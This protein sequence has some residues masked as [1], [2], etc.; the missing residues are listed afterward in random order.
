MPGAISAC[1]LSPGYNRALH[2]PDDSTSPMKNAPSAQ[3]V[4]VALGIVTRQTNQTLEILI[5]QRK[6]DQVLSG[7]WEFPGGKLEPGETPAHCVERE[8]LEEVGLVVQAHTPLPIIE[9]QYPHANVRLHPYLCRYLSGH[10]QPLHVAACR[11]VN[12]HDLAQYHFPSA[13]TP[14]LAHL[15]QSL[16]G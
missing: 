4:R 13:N 5:S 7:Y 6:A 9:H 1:V 8:M 10:A 16:V 12:L 2:P 3:W 14:L 15:Q 11:W